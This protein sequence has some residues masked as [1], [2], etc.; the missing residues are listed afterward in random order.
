MNLDMPHSERLMN[1]VAPWSLL[2]V[3][4]TLQTAAAQNFEPVAVPDLPQVDGSSVAWADF[5][6]DNRLDF[7]MLGTTNGNASGAIAQLWRNTGTTFT[8]V[9]IDELPG[10]YLGC[11]AWGDY[12]SDGRIDFLISG[13]RSA[14]GGI[15]PTTQVWRNTATGFSNVTSSV[16]S[17]LPNASQSCAAWADFN[18]DGKL[19][20]FFAGFSS[21]GKVAGIWLN[22]GSHFTN[23]TSSIAPGLLGVDLGS[24]SVADFNNDG[25]PDLL[26]TGQLPNGQAT[27]Q[28]WQNNESGFENVTEALA[29]GLPPIVN[30]S[31][32]WAD[33]D[34]DG[35]LDLI[36][37]GESTTPR[38]TQLW[39]NTGTG[40]VEFEVE[41]LAP[42]RLGHVQFG[43]VNNDG[44]LDFVVTGDIV[45]MD[46]TA[47][48]LNSGNGFTNSGLSLPGAFSFANGS[49][50]LADFDNDGRLDLLLS[51]MGPGSR[52]TTL[53]RNNL[54]IESNAAPSAPASPVA[55]VEEGVTTLSWSPATDSESETNLTYNIA[56][57]TTSGADDIVSA[58]ADASGFRKIVA[59]G[60]AG[61][62][63][64]LKLRLPPGSYFWK[65]QAIDGAYAGGA[66]SSE[67]TFEVLPEAAPT[68]TIVSTGA[69][70]TISWEPATP[71]WILQE[72]EN[73]NPASWDDAPSGSQNP[74]QLPVEDGNR[75]FRLHRP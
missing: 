18:L 13:S 51:G 59:H 22:T 27:I 4:L 1:R 29:P 61:L 41:G 73:I 10:L 2:L 32:A 15:S 64:S 9:A 44:L 40:F 72:S 74:V 5:D 75:F 24:V 57:G 21:T 19:D 55:T 52:T 25:R 36:L 65:V 42:S 11:V 8:N 50:A 17:D 23:A 66:F 43:D 31:T 60:N 63:T 46:T 69:T 70:V 47:I 53:L 30:G 54:S 45:G 12:D 62:N 6:N 49:A 3:T 68:L 28:L 56:I 20:L 7:L 26:L 16:F 58:N 39:R 67:Q 37:N 38:V 48:W 35:R 71:G 34:N 14:N 33:F